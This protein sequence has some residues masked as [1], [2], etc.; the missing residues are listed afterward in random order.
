MDRSKKLQVIQ[1]LIDQGF[2]GDELE[3]RARRALATPESS[4]STAE[5]GVVA[6]KKRSTRNDPDS[7]PS[8]SLPG[9]KK[10]T[11]DNNPDDPN[12]MA[13]LPEDPKAK[14][15]DSV[16]SRHP[17]AEQ[18]DNSRAYS[19]ALDKTQEA[20]FQKWKSTLPARL[21]SENDYDLRGFYKN[22]PNWSPDSP[23]AHMTDEFKKPNHPTFSNE[24]KYYNPST[25]DMGGKWNGDVFLPNNI[26]NK[27]IQDERIGGEPFVETRPFKFLNTGP[28]AAGQLKSEAAAVAPPSMGQAIST[29]ITTPVTDFLNTV[30]L[31]G[32]KTA[33]NAIG[34]A[35]SPQATA[36]ANALESQYHEAV[37][38]A[39]PIAKAA[40]YMS[41]VGLP[42]MI[43]RSAL[44]ATEAA[45]G[46]IASRLPGLAERIA[47]KPV[48]SAAIKGAAVG[49]PTAG[50]SSL[51][52]DVTEG[53]P[54][55]EALPRAKEAT[56]GG[57][58]LGAGI[59]GLVGSSAGARERVTGRIEQDIGVGEGGKAS[60][61]TRSKIAS[62]S[63]AGG[64]EGDRALLT[65][66]LDEDPKLAKV[67]HGKAKTEPAKA[68]DAIDS[69]IDSL[70]SENA[71]AYAKIEE[72]TKAKSPPT[73]ED[74][75]PVPSEVSP[76]DELTTSHRITPA[77]REAFQGEMRS[78]Y[79]RELPGITDVPVGGIESAT[80]EAST[81][82]GNKRTN[83]MLRRA[84][85]LEHEAQ[86]MAARHS[87]NAR[88]SVPVNK[89][90]LAA[91]KLASDRADVI[92]EIAQSEMLGEARRLRSENTSDAV[93]NIPDEPITK[94]TGGIDVAAPITRLGATEASL[95]E[96]GDFATAD[97]LKTMHE[98]LA[99]EWNGKSPSVE[100][101]R[102]VAT[103][104]G[105]AAFPEGTMDPGAKLVRAKAS[106]MVW[107]ELSKSIEDAAEEANKAG[108]NINVE[109]LR[110]NNRKL[111]LLIPAKQALSQRAD[112]VRLNQNSK[113]ATI[114]H[115]IKHPIDTSVDALTG[116]GDNAIRSA[117]YALSRSPSG[118]VSPKAIAGVVQY[119][120][121]GRSRE[122]I[123]AF[124]NDNGIPIEIADKLADQY[125][126]Q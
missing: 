110:A 106:R 32:Y 123:H 39:E 67:L 111:S 84:D 78:A 45:G 61:S 26:A 53:V 63:D 98:K 57:A 77:E 121:S 122:E 47:A 91:R 65:K 70:N 104:I 29:G 24:S 30:T 28:D 41:P 34:N 82:A 89:D 74:V 54:M 117:D 27:N 80:S 62:R 37:P 9:P 76:F 73:T 38:M 1:S 107:S 55:S 120:R 14:S 12:S 52:E 4:D 81:M 101:V 115:A 124:A 118:M 44:T 11:P 2:E 10:E 95:R 49:A 51:A 83:P 119:A 87:K 40:G 60:K 97:A 116:A 48:M 15:I 79:G 94:S 58:A 35:I 88:R 112:N 17:I 68:R 93:K 86:R 42:N 16:Q 18:I 100:A 113:L 108:A 105:N 102:K 126:N 43:G 33:R 56:I 69:R 75:A 90:D 92:G 5:G 6:G 103:D 36:G 8:E 114:G 64:D 23:D 19:T 7:Q 71:K 125:G 109:R 13:P 20:G 85:M 59:G 21:Q 31:G 66:V 50:A 46:A 3:K 99:T 22:N 25:A 72:F 96:S